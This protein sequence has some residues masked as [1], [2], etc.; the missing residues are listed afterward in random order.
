M[1]AIFVFRAFCPSGVGLPLAG[2]VRGF[3]WPAI[4]RVAT[5]SRFQRFWFAMAS[6]R[7]ASAGSSKWRAASAQISSGT[8]SGRIGQPGDRLSQGQCGS[9]GVAV[10]RRLPPASQREEALSVSTALFWKRQAPSRHT[11]QPLI[12]LARIPARWI[13]AGGTRSC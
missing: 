2:G 6:A 12:W 9:L 4:W 13:V 10:V 1:V 5:F 3:H 8:G 11:P 7:P